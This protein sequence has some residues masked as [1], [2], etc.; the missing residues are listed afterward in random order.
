MWKDFQSHVA[1]SPDNFAIACVH[2]PAGLFDLPNIP[3]DEDAFRA[4]PYLRWSFAT[5]SHGVERLARAWR[6]LGVK[7]STPVVTFV[8]NSAEYVLTAYAAIKLGCVLIPI[9]PRNLTNEVEVRHMVKTALSVCNGERP[10]VVAGNEH[11]AFRIDELGLLPD[12][13]KIIVGAHMY[14]NWAT[15]QSLMDQSVQS[16]GGVLTPSAP[17]KGGSVL[18]TSGTTSL[19][20]GIHRLHANW[21]IAYTGWSE[22]EGHMGSGDSV[23]CNLPNN[24]AM[25]LICMSNALG[26]GAAIIL[27]GPAFD[28][29]LMLETLFT[30]KV[31]H[32]I[33]VPTMI[34]GLVAVKAAKYPDRPLENMKKITF[35][36]TSLTL[37]TLNLVTRE[38][39]ACGAENFYGCTEGA[40]STSGSM[41]DFS[42]IADGVDV[43]VGWPFPG[44]GLRIVDPE[45]NEM[46]PRG[47]QGEIHACGPSVDGPYIG[48]IGA[49]NW[50]ES[51]G[52]LW[53]K[54]GD[55]GRMDD[56]GRTF[57]TGRY[58]DM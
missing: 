6:P 37:E 23:V 21:A 34:H 51:D 5:L 10:I 52:R 55:A 25:G 41:S 29:E 17:D 11:L 43:S 57:V 56:R 40:L 39:G 30:E 12:A 26:M 31:T 33:M 53:Y 8:Q 14:S 28:P 32:S 18:F 27:P 22:L 24:H 44:Y 3:L 42:K 36:G 1:S 19:P 46:V 49:D 47:S 45:T 13:V 54:T 2:Q 50:Y 20:K 38:L 16:A 7:E 35:G 9:N 4:N 58:K 48:G 15:F